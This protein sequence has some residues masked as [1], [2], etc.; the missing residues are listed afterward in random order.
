MAERRMFAK[1]ITNSD[2][3]LDMPLSSQCLYFHLSMNADDEGFV[4]RAKSIM[5]MVGAK[6]DDLKVLI[7]KSFII[8]FETGVIVIKHWKINNYL[9]NDRI[10]ETNY[11]NEKSLLS[12][13][14]NGSYTL[15]RQVVGNCQASGRQ[16]EAQYSIGK[17]SIG[18]DS[19]EEESIC[20]EEKPLCEGEPSTPTPKVKH[21]HGIYKQVTLTDDEIK[22]LDNEFGEEYIKQVIDRIDELVKMNGNKYKWKDFNLVIRKVIRENWSIIKDLKI[23]KNDCGDVF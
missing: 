4:D 16:V 12:L 9:R 23:E 18:K 2:A 11:T 7:S 3:F 21:K 10:T 17:D 15:G 13:K 8:P 5:R 1:A 20:K 6:D 14:D 19:I 22:R